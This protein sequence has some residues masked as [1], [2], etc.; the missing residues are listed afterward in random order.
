MV[1]GT[2]LIATAFSSYSKQ[3]DIILFASGVSNSAETNRESFAKERLLLEH[4]CQCLK[5]KLII[6]FSTSSVVDLELTESPYIIHK[7]RMES[8]VAQCNNYMIFRLPQ[9]VGKTKNPHT[10]VNFLYHHII[11]GKKFKVWQGACRNLIDVAD[12]YRIAD[13]FIK[14]QIFT[15]QVTTIATPINVKILD[16]VKILEKVIHKQA[17]FEILEQGSCYEIDINHLIPYL[18]LLQISFSQD[19]PEKLINKYYGGQ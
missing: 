15:N 4:T 14:H 19:Y 8:M 11:E 7:L 12:V 3:N 1:I 2:G 17:S 9:V 5:N 13:Y 16:L 18:N 6:Y 10:I